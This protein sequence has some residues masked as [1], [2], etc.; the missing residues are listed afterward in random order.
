METIAREDFTN[1]FFQ[2]LKETFE[3]PPPGK[4]SAYLDKGAGLFLTLDQ[5]TA[6]AASTS[7]SPGAPTIAAHCEHV[8]FYVMAL[9][10]FMRGA[11]DKIDW[12]QSWLVQAVTP[13]QWD[14]LKAQ[15]R[16]AY[17]T[18]N[19][20]LQ[21]VAAWGDDEVGDAMAILVHTAYHLGA[22]RHLARTL[23]QPT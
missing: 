10:D 5:L 8:R 6:E 21:S 3:G 22:I 16:G 11:T 20:H 18:V 13:A 14:D 23:A 15:L 4:G 9:L 2:L 17:T 12:K 7:V 1:S 19:E